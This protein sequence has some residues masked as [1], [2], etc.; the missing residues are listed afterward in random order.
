MNAFSV[1]WLFWNI[2][3]E[4][5]LAKISTKSA[6]IHSGNL[7]DYVVQWKSNNKWVKLILS[8]FWILSKDLSSCTNKKILGIC[9]NLSQ[10]KKQLNIFSNWNFLLFKALNPISAIFENAKISFNLFQSFLTILKVLK[11]IWIQIQSSKH[12]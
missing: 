9:K 4:S 11:N 8:T 7:E 5:I 3:K 6:V 12:P 1:S 2:H 10:F